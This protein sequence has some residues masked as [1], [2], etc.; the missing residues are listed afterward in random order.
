MAP[1]PSAEPAAIPAS[2]GTGAGADGRFG[3]RTKVLGLTILLGAEV[4]VCAA[5]QAPFQRFYRFAFLDSGGELVLQ[6]LID[7][8]YRPT[9]DFGHFYG[10]VPLLISRAWYGLVG[11]TPAAFR[12]ET[13]LCSLATAWGLARFAAYRGLGPA[14][15]ALIALAVPDLL[16][17]AQITLVHALEQAVLV[18]GLAEHARG[19]RGRA[20]ACATACCFIKPS[21]GYVY[22]LVLL[23]AIALAVRRGDRVSWRRVLG[24]AAATGAV[25]AAAV[26]SA[27]GLVPLAVSLWP[28]KGAAMYRASRMGFF[29]GIGRDFWVLRGAGPIDYFRYETG[30]WLIGTLVLAWGGLAALTRLARGSAAGERAWD[31]EVVATCA[32]LHVAF[33]T[34]FFGHRG[35]W[36]YYF[37][38]LV[39][40]LGTMARGGPRPAALAWILA[41]LLAV[42]DRSKLVEVRRQWAAD[43]P[44]AATLG[45]WA[46][47][48]ERAEWIRVLDLVRG[49]G[50]VLLAPCEGAAVLVPGFAPPI[51]GYFV[52]GYAVRP[53]VRRKAAQLEAAEMIVAAVPPDWHGFADWPALS[54][55]LEGCDLVWRG[56]HCRVYRRRGGAGGSSSGL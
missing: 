12:A 46:T 21:M 30:F 5:I 37:A 52:P 27:F 34:L 15:V 31:D 3:L 2:G 9:V 18:H 49:H 14:G 51:G 50:P 40:G 38:V 54:A 26:A 17:P 4:L 22:G 16:L 7:R 32:A 48:E 56:E 35:S 53:E 47:S 42:S 45:L 29:H 44:S 43:A 25:L 55:A 20:L 8:G 6:R 11:L 10:L 36:V 19:R 13:L 23:I 41:V 28:A 39:L 33:V 24:P 1:D